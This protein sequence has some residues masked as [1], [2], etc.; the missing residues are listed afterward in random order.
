M[1]AYIK[2]EGGPDPMLQPL[3]A[4][5]EAQIECEHT[6]HGQAGEQLP[7]MAF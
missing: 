5:C 6:V 2:Q 4:S 1:Q 7:A 3:A